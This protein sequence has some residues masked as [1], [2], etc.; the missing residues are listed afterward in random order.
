M[1]CLRPSG[2]KIASVLTFFLAALSSSASAQT[3]TL[4]WS[5]E[6][7]GS[8]AVDPSNWTYDVGGGGWGNS[9]LEYY[10]PGALNASQSGGILTIQARNE[11][12]GG[13]AYTSARLKT[14]GIRNFGPYGKIEGRISGPDGQGLWPAF[15]MLGSNIAT[16]PW[17]GCGE[18][19]IMEHINAVPT[20]F[21]T[22]HWANPGYAFYTAAHTAMPDFQSY[23]T[24][25][26]EWTPAYLRWVVDGVNQGEG[27]ITGGINGTD[28]FNTNSFFI[29]L[30]LAVGGSWPGNPDSTT[31][32]PANLNIDY[33]RSYTAA[34]MGTPT[35][36]TTSGGTPTPT[37]SPT[38]PPVADFTQSVTYLNTTQA[39][40]GFVPNG[41]VPGYVILH[42]TPPGVSQQNVQMVWNADAGRWEFTM[43][44]LTPGAVVPYSF[45]YQKNGPQFDSPLFSYTHAVVVTPTPTPSPTPTATPLPT[46]VPGPPGPQGPTGPQ[47]PAGP[48]GPQG[49][50]GA[51]GPAGPS[52]PAGA[53]GPAGAQGIPG[54][55]ALG[56]LLAIPVKSLNAPPP[57][58]PQG[59]AFIGY[60]K[61]LL[62]PKHSGGHHD[63]DDDTH[64]AI[65]MK[66]E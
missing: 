49:P 35:P 60:L 5:D 29:V 21:G 30:N 53:T 64:F 24:Y 26:L 37:P 39:M 27:N 38:M 47:G 41:F 46:G 50:A 28:V 51:Q 1:R 4:A 2:W 34:D 20:I 6:F 18:I 40:V 57:K 59:Y 65:Y 12:V 19:D 55:T 25:A 10:Q 31:V 11:S 48:Q 32:F 17:P 63:D 23:H 36:T 61:P 43:S 52:G 7:N 15:W 16:V 62:Q 8:G 9:E 45:T 14:Q 54:P 3:W 42:F 33:V 44:G 56:S 22:M 66:S 58:A 13:N